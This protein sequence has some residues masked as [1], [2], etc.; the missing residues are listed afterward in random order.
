MSLLAH[1]ACSFPLFRSR[2]SG[3]DKHRHAG[4]IKPPNVN[5]NY[6][7]DSPSLMD[8]HT[9]IYIILIPV[10]HKTQID[11]IVSSSFASL[12]AHEVFQLI[13]K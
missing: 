12:I 6:N 3:M 8:I 7:F 1:L 10:R 4:Q 9:Y 5:A 11:K 13:L 2:G